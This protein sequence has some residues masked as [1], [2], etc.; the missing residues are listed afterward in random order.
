MNIHPDFL[1]K[2][3][4]NGVKLV[5][6]E[7]SS[8]MHE[9]T[10]ASV[11][12]LLNSKYNVY[13]TEHGSILKEINDAAWQSAGYTSR[14]DAVD[15]LST[16][17]CIDKSLARKIMH[18]DTVVLSE[19]RFYYFDEHAIFAGQKELHGISLKMPCYDAGE[20]LQGV[21]GCSILTDGIS[22]AELATALADITNLFICDQRQHVFASQFNRT[23]QLSARE[24]EL[25]YWY[26]RGKNT[27]EI[28]KLML[29]SYRTV[30]YYLVNIKDKLGVSSRSELLELLHTETLSS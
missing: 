30:E 26:R 4:K 19:Q 27:R 22:N 20:N 29:I 5:A 12:E 17:T 14:A 6:P 10:S 11:G 9:P 21:F 15:Y 2:K 18:N 25:I 3:F 23:Y 8:L 24:R 13:F 1:V 7:A 28:A 16:R